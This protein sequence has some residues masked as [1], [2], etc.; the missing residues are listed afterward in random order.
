MLSNTRKPRI[1]YQGKLSYSSPRCVA[2]T[3]Q[4]LNQGLEKLTISVLPGEE[5]E[6]DSDKAQARD[7][8]KPFGRPMVKQFNFLD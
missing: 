1:P 6:E 5:I 4:V 8:M 2:P 3:Q 7:A